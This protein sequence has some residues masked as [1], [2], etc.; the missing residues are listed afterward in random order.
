ML[1]QQV[2]N[3]FIWLGIG[4]KGVLCERG[5][6]GFVFFKSLDFFTK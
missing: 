2:W 6:E 5:N 1:I 3:G 4:T